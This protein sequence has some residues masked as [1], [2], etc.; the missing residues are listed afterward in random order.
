MLG[1][2]AGPLA[3]QGAR[4]SVHTGTPAGRSRSKG[5]RFRES[6]V[7][8][9]W[10][11][12]LTDGALSSSRELCP[13]CGQHVF[14]RP[15]GKAQVP[16]GR[17]PSSGLCDC[18]PAL[19]QV[20]LASRAQPPPLT[21]TERDTVAL[22]SDHGAWKGGRGLTDVNGEGRERCR[23]CR[24]SLSW[25][26]LHVAAP[27]GAMHRDTQP[28]RSQQPVAFDQP[29]QREDSPACSLR[30]QE[31][32]AVTAHPQA[33]PCPGPT[34]PCRLAS[35]RRVTAAAA[36]DTHRP[37]GVLRPGSVPLGMAAAAILMMSAWRRVC[38]LATADTPVM[39]G[40]VGC[41]HDLTRK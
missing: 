2:L 10:V 1:R 12:A 32:G 25:M 11:F 28:A 29:P 18:H 22:C 7:F 21:T 40:R 20:L 16:R 37:C 6:R 9:A 19:V 23:L 8:S 17:L 35:D 33:G 24:R 13:C 36:G 26:S 41:F 27:P 4:P 15:L 38:S 31:D 34:C 30:G 5:K 3:S 14:S 39:F